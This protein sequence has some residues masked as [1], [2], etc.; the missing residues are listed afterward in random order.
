[1]KGEQAETATVSSDWI[2]FAILF[3]SY[4]LPHTGHHVFLS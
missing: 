3:V 4:H 1:M 2:V